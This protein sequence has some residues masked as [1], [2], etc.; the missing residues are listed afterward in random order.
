MEDVRAI[1][2][3]LNEKGIFVKSVSLFMSIRKDGS[4]FML[5]DITRSDIKFL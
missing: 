1:L 3:F 4:R 5:E 2:F